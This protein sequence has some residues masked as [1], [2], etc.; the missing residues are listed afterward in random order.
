MKRF[1]ILLLTVIIALS[2]ASCVSQPDVQVAATTAPVYFFTSSLCQGTDITV[3]QLITERV[4]CL[5]DYTLQTDQMRIVEAAQLLVI[6]GAGLEDFLADAVAGTNS[7]LDAS[8]N[9]PLLCADSEDAHS[10]AHDHTYDPHIWL[11]PVHAQQMVIN[12]ADGLVAFYP[13]H[14]TQIVLNQEKLLSDLDALSK[15]ANDQLSSL[16]S[17]KL[18]TFHDGFGYLAEAFDMQIVH[19]IEEEAGSEASAAELIHLIG[20]VNENG[21]DC[22]FTEY[23]GSAPAAKIVANE[24]GARIFSLDMA[25]TDRG[26]FE[27]MYYNIDTLKEALG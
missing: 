7:V 24:T 3:T 10:H 2:L 8:S 20:L 13:Q 16:S 5:H 14:K 15:Y 12:I 11:S 17:R 9:I 21:L 26:Y 6:S 25:M 1:L 19:T 18:I 27:A 23:N 4:S 22:I